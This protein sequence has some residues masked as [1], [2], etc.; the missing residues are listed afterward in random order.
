[1]SKHL[2]LEAH[3]GEF[4]THLLRAKSLDRNLFFVWTTIA[5]RL[6][7]TVNH[8]LLSICSWVWWEFPWNLLDFRMPF[9]KTTPSIFGEKYIVSLSYHTPF[10]QGILVHLNVIIDV[11]SPLLFWQSVLTCFTLVY[12]NCIQHIVGWWWSD[13]AIHVNEGSHPHQQGDMSGGPK[14]WN[15]KKHGRQLDSFRRWNVTLTC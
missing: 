5:P 11:E 6:I 15:P 2:P 9:R 13:S 8:H 7:K 4:Q 3:F 12:L 1:M 14:R 10:L